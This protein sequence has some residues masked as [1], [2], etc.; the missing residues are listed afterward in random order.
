MC[1][2][3]PP[4]AHTNPVQ[5]CEAAQ[6]GVKRLAE[7]GRVPSAEAATLPRADE[8]R[9][10]SLALSPSLALSLSLS[11]S[12]RNPCLCHHSPSQVRAALGN[13]QAATLPRAH[14]V[15]SLGPNNVLSRS[16]PIRLAPSAWLTAD[17]LARAGAALLVYGALCIR[18]GPSLVVP[19]TNALTLSP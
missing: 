6:L 11:L 15:C 16:V 18:K 10:L 19:K 9:S 17:R 8:V 14:E 4:Q 12:G 3:R 2:G 7:R 1:H 13:C 5:S